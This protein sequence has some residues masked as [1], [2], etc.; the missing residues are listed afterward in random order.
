MASPSYGRLRRSIAAVACVVC[1]AALLAGSRAAGEVTDQPLRV[2]QMNLCNSGIAGCYTGRS[3]AAAAEVIRGEAPDVVTLNEVCED[4]VEV[5]R[6]ALSG[7][8][9]GEPVL[10]AFRAAYDRRTASDFRCRNGHRYGVGLLVHLP[11]RYRGHTTYGGLYPVQDP[12]DPEERAWVCVLAAG[13]FYACTTHLAYTSPSIALAQ[14]RYLLDTAIPGMRAQDG[15]LPTVL[16]GD[17]NLRFG[18]T[19]DVRSCVP[20]GH[21]RTDDG[22]VQQVVAT[23]DLTV[24][25]SKLIEMD[26]TTDHPSLLVA[27]TVP[28]PPGR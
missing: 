26:G 13:A 4:D 28:G 18:D 7:V 15:Y 6:R 20:A 12:D 9:P 10:S 24:R 3:V 5:L 2:L 23:A 14:C 22:G 16:G 11:Q 25:F 1:T 21:L 8:H 19:P 27:L 17:L